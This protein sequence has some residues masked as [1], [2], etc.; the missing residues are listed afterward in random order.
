MN[1]PSSSPDS[2]PSFV[3]RSV[4]WWSARQ[5]ADAGGAAPTAGWTSR[6]VANCPD[7]L[8]Y[9]SAV[10]QLQ[11]GLRQ[12]AQDLA[13][14][15]DEADIPLGLEDRIWA[16]VKPEVV[17]RAPRVRRSLVSQWLKLEVGA[18]AAIAVAAVVWFG[19]GRVSPS[20][21]VQVP[22]PVVA[23]FDQ[24]DLQELAASLASLPQRVLAPSAEATVAAG[25]TGAL[26]TELSA[27]GSDTRAVW[28]FLER[29]FLPSKGPDEVVSS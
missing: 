27:L 17:P 7:C 18:L 1:A 12:E 8:N 13:T 29:S 14:A 23:D 19:W 15:V 16:A 5:D 21:P 9:F 24:A 6:H 20:A 3:C 22:A 25:S 26:E 10:S 11:T 28:E 4:R 2:S